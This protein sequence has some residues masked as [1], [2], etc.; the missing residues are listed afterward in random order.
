MLRHRSDE[1]V[2]EGRL[3]LSNLQFPNGERVEVVVTTLRS[4]PAKRS[5]AEVRRILRG[6]VERYDDPFEPAIP[7]DS[8]EMLQ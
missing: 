4:V 5:I 6:G 7:T 8:W 3:V 1:V 2:R